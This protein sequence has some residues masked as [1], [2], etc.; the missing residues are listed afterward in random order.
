V[1]S[2]RQGVNISYAYLLPGLYHDDLP[3]I[4]GFYTTNS[5]SDIHTMGTK[6]PPDARLFSLI[7]FLSGL[8]R[9]GQQSLPENV[10]CSATNS[11]ISA[12]GKLQNSC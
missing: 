7:S 6:A 11:A 12:T 3:A 4:R 5:L 9:C 10:L 8:S 1:T 2:N